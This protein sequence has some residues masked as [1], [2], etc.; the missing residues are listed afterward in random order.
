MMP[1]KFKLR[2]GF[3]CGCILVAAVTLTRFVMATDFSNPV[4]PLLTAADLERDFLVNANRTGLDWLVKSNRPRVHQIVYAN[5]AAGVSDAGENTNSCATCHTSH[6]SSGR[7]FLSQ[8]SQFISGGEVLISSYN[9]CINC[10]GGAIGYNV[11]QGTTMYSNPENNPAH[12]SG[13]GKFFEGAGGGSDV[14]FHLATGARRHGNAPGAN[15]SLPGNWSQPLTCSSCH[16]P[17]GTYSGR[18]LHYNPNKRAVRHENLPLV[19]L[20][21]GAYRIA[22]TSLTPWL[23]YPGH[24]AEVHDSVYNLITNQFAI[25]YA[26]GLLTRVSGTTEPAFVTFYRAQVLGM[27]IEN[28]YSTR[29]ESPEKVIH[30]SGVNQFCSSCHANYTVGDRVYHDGFNH[31]IGMDVTPWLPVNTRDVAIDA[32]ALEKSD[33]TNRLTC[34]TCHYAHGTDLSRLRRR[35]LGWAWG[36]VWALE[37]LTDRGYTN[38]IHPAN[39]RNLRFFDPD[40]ADGFNGRREVCFLCHA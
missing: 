1:G 13:A 5:P 26:R 29:E 36:S 21:G 14:S 20:G 7:P 17:H 3:I 33:G 23:F 8:N 16:G 9:T 24:A 40:N 4:G 39:T 6:V 31:R 28:L 12:W 35:A 10:H 11:L 22:D 32:L 38:P 18:L 37:R 19:S 25:N 30:R 15:I 27:T 34:L 2:T